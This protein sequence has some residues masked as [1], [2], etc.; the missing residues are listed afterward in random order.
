MTYT[1]LFVCAGN[2]G[3]S[4][5]AEAIARRLLAESLN[6]GDDQLE[7]YGL[8]VLSAGTEAPEGIE[9]SSRGV[10]LAAEIGIV[11]NRRP[12]RRRPA[13]P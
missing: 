5:L 3:R 11:M 2:V 12:A 9:T 7:S 4:P 6:V 10:T 13:V 1:V 8:R